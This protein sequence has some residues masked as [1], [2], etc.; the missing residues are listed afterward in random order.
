[1]TT[2]KMNDS[3]RAA[4]QRM[5]I[6]L[7]NEFWGASARLGKFH[8]RKEFVAQISIQALASAVIN[9]LNEMDE[10][11]DGLKDDEPIITYKGQHLSSMRELFMQYLTNAK[12]R[13][14]KR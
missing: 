2:E 10:I 1:M 13:E 14:S 3:D 6:A 12:I 5:T 8:A 4:L 11:A 7:M 9:I